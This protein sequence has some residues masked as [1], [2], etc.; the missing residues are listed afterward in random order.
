MVAHDCVQTCSVCEP[1]CNDGESR[2]RG[3]A[4]MF[5]IDRGTE[6]YVNILLVK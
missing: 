5:R 4:H 6:L 1:E 2:A 3:G